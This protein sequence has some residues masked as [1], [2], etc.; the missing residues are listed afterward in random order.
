MKPLPRVIIV[1]SDEDGWM[2]VG[3]FADQADAQ[4]YIERRRKQWE[5]KH[6]AAGILPFVTDRCCYN[7]L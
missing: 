4:G 2:I 3:P 1:G 6:W 7:S 5:L